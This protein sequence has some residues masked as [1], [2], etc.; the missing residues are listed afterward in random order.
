MASDGSSPCGTSI[1]M[2]IEWPVIPSGDKHT[3]IT[4]LR[5]E[6]AAGGSFRYCHL[7]PTRAVWKVNSIETPLFSDYVAIAP[8]HSSSHS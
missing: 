3:I 1:I 8:L 4:D 2:Y 6:I 7:P 5:A